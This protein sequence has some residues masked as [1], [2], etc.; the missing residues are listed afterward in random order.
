[1]ALPYKIVQAEQQAGRE[2]N[3]SKKLIICKKKLA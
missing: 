1:V 2:K 3:F